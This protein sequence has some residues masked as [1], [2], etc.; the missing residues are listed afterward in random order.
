MCGCVCDIFLDLF[1]IAKM[2]KGVTVADAYVFELGD[3]LK[4]LAEKELRETAAT[5]DFALTALRE[6]IEANPRIASARLGECI[7][8]LAQSVLSMCRR[9]LR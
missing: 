1:S 2:S 7:L 4:E 8:R 6:W 5:R 3:A 9:P